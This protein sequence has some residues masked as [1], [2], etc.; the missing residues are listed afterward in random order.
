MQTLNPYLA[1]ILDELDQLFNV[2]ACCSE[3]QLITHLQA[4]KI[5]PFDQFSLAQPKDLF[6]AHFLCMHALYQLKKH[7]QEMQSYTLIIQS[8]QI[9]RIA[10]K[11]INPINELPNTAVEISDP[12]ESYYLNAAH[13]FETQEDEIN[14]LLKAFWQKY[15]AQDH[16]MQALDVLNLPA[17][18]DAKMLKEQYRRLAQQHHPDK[19]GC[20]ETFA[21][22]HQAKTIL[23]KLI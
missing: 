5:A 23:D 10:I 16:K 13:Y 19:G 18:A 12:L 4:H 1:P 8:V 3:H 2:S 20:A 11:A 15:L 22:I 9:Q 17:N 7:Y 21:K 14:D 6:S